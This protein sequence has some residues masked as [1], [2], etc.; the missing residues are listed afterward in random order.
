MNMAGNENKYCGNEHVVRR[1]ENKVLFECG[2]GVTAAVTGLV[3]RQILRNGAEKGMISI[4]ML[5]SNL[6]QDQANICRV[7]FVTYFDG[8][9]LKVV[10]GIVLT[11]L[12]LFAFFRDTFE[13]SCISSSVIRR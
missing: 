4:P 13:L 12:A 2:N 10:D 11:A 5:L 8:T 7:L 6:E 3:S 9:G 1:N